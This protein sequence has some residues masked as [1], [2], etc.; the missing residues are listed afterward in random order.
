VLVAVSVIRIEVLQPRLAT[1]A[2]PEISPVIN[3]YSREA[4]RA[5]LLSV[6]PVDGFILPGPSSRH[7][8]LRHVKCMGPTGERRPFGMH[9]AGLLACLCLCRAGAA[10][11]ALR[12]LFR[13]GCRD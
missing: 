6:A 3:L 4:H 7:L 10:H 13:T 5:S 11:G 12:R 8:A 9:T 2:W 1:W